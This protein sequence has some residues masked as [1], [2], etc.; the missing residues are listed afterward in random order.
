MQRTINFKLG[1]DLLSDYKIIDTS[2]NSE[3]S[4][5]LIAEA[6][7]ALEKAEKYLKG[8]GL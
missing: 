3:L 6:E 5:S 7:Y 8:N 1:V 4:K 2:S